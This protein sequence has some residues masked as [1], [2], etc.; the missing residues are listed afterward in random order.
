MWPADEFRPR[1]WYRFVSRT[2]A[3][4][5]EKPD[6]SYVGVWMKDIEKDRWIHLATTRYPAVIADLSDTFGFLEKFGGGR[7]P[8]ASFE[9]RNLYTRRDGQWVPS[10]RLWVMPQGEERVGLVPSGTGALV[11]AFYP[12]SYDATAAMKA[13]PTY[14]PKRQSLTIQQPEQPEFLE[15]AKV[16]AL[17][18]RQQGKQLAVRWEVTGAPQLGYRLEVFDNA[19]GQGKPKLVV[20][21]RDPEMR[22]R[23][24]EGEFGTTPSVRLVLQDIF[25]G[26]SEPTL[27]A[28][29]P[30]L[31]LPAIPAAGKPGLLYRY[32]EAPRG[33]SFLA[34]PDFV[35]LKPV[36]EGVV[37]C[38]DLQPRWR[39]TEYAFA[40][41]GMF[42][43]SETGLH[44]FR[45]T[46]ASGAKLLVDG[47]P[48]VDADGYH[49]IAP[50]FGCVSLEKG[51]HKLELQYCQG[52]R[53][54]QQSD[55]FLQLACARPGGNGA[56]AAISG[57]QFRHSETPAGTPASASFETAV[58]PDGTVRLT[59]TGADANDRFEF[60]AEAP[61]FDYF[62]EQ[63]ASG[64]SYLVA[65]T[66]AE[67]PVT[68]TPWGGSELVVRARRFSKG[69]D[70]IS[71]SVDSAPVIVSLPKPEL[72][73][74][75]LTELE[76]HMYPVRAVVGT[77][78][79]RLVGESMSLLT[80]PLKGDG[81]IIARLA[82]IT[83]DQPMPDGTRPDLGNWEAGIIWRHDLRPSPGEPL[84]GNTHYA[85]VL[86]RA[87][88]QICFCD[89][90]MKN[91]AGNQPSGN[92]GWNKR[93]MKLERKGIDLICSVSPDGQAW[94]VVKTASLP[95][96]GETAQVGFFIYAIP[97]ATPMP[98]SANFDHIE[99]RD[100]A[101]KKLP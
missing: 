57:G 50:H 83:T 75:T 58:Q 2:W 98:H 69:A 92:L 76:H 93:W 70:G 34:L 96:M 74:W 82:D 86:A 4:E 67:T 5:G 35:K 30:T 23:L 46:C 101:G 80:R 41:N 73:P 100:A 94:Q 99:V 38:P 59:P 90:L 36:S 27:A 26:R 89:S 85:S 64:A 72:G 39:R 14:L 33:A 52:P 91:G 49:G 37:A 55:D 11:S 29:T 18:V 84:G 31:P 32:Y 61:G 63:G 62:A 66:K 87:D 28:A 21:A 79:V 45:M 68:F 65:E 20:E 40:F 22:E 51:W 17:V 6:H 7:G 53:Q 44:Q 60:Y 13:E 15:P 8:V 25:D 16:S 81:T 77:D 47:Q 88:G 56:F 3:A 1:A 71:R 78:S 43:A 9:I 54:L 19:A 42:E 10:N 95:K 12:D 97:S 24:L 48:V